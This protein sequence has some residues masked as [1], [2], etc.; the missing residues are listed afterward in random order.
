MHYQQLSQ[1]SETD[2]TPLAKA[3]SRQTGLA[4]GSV[5]LTLHG[6]RA[7]E[8][9]K[10]GDRIISRNI[11][12]AVLREVRRDTMTI[13]PVL[14]KAGSIGHTRPM[15][16]VI[17]PPDTP[18]HIRDWRAMALYGHPTANVAARRLVDGEF[19]IAL[20]AREITV[21][22]LIFDASHV[23]YATGLEVLAS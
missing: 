13:A 4:E 16:D 8:A 5:I 22:K 14:I 21:Y 20:P 1:R 23:I 3:R 6:E 7:V 19:V 10:P 15:Q 9:L 11:G 17:L 18:V 12:T 2:E